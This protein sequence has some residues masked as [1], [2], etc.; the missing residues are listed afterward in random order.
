MIGGQMLGASSR[1]MRPFGRTLFAA[2]GTLAVACVAAAPASADTQR[3]QI[4]FFFPGV[5]QVSIHG[6]GGNTSSCTSFET[7]RTLDVKDGEIV[8][9]GFES[10]CHATSPS[11]SDF[12]IMVKNKGPNG[13]EIG[14]GVISFEDTTATTHSHDYEVFCGAYRSSPEKRTP[15]IGIKCTRVGTHFVDIGL[16]PQTL[17]DLTIDPDSLRVTHVARITYK[18]TAAWDSRLRVK[19]CSV[20]MNGCKRWV[21][22][23]EVTRE[24]VPGVNSVTLFEGHLGKLILKPGRY[25]L[26]LIGHGNRSFNQAVNFELAP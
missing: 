20:F 10:R 16:G 9:A 21:T 18:D 4:R 14:S 5:R 1:V 23:G 24:D 13:A 26:E 2:L 22:L 25:R 19:K 11:W 12:K 6:G 7:Y 17:S 15:W 8:E 3:F